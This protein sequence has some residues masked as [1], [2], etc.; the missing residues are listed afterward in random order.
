V[1]VTEN[2]RGKRVLVTN[3]DGIDGPG[4]RVLVAALVE[5]GYEPIVVAPDSDYSGAGTS[6]IGKSTSSV[7]EGQRQLAYEKR[8]LAEAPHVE[9]YAI[10]APPA[11]CTLLSMRGAFGERPDL[12]ASGINY[13]LNT[14]PAVRHSGT[15][16][17]A[18]TAAGFGVPALALSAEFN[19]Q[20]P[21]TPPRYDTAAAVGMQLLAV[22]ADSGHAVLNLN[23]PQCS[24][25]ELA[26][27]QTAPLSPITSFFSHVEDRTDKVLNIGFSISD[28]PVP[29]DTDTGLIKAGYAAVSSLVG[30]SAIDCSDVVARVVEAAD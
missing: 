4:L 8:V 9:A 25:N 12:V 20:D 30:V 21:D 18:L 28:E 10:A 14:G 6:I 7:N 16:A 1:K 17:A 15:V 2:L 19:F 24:V 5:H 11:M 3:D 22:L 27:V 23:T 29:G 13:G 26:G